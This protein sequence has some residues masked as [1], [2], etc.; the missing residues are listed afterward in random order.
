MPGALCGY[1]Q[2]I[3]AAVLGG[4]HCQH[5]FYCKLWGTCLLYPGSRSKARGTETIFESSQSESRVP[6]LTA[7]MSCLLIVLTHRFQPAFCISDWNQLR[8]G[9]QDC[10]NHSGRFHLPRGCSILLKVNTTSSRQVMQI[11]PLHFP[12]WNYPP[13]TVWFQ[14][15]IPESHFGAK[16][17]RRHKILEI[18]GEIPFPRRFTAIK[19]LLMNGSSVLQAMEVIAFA[20]SNHFLQ[21]PQL[22][23]SFRMIGI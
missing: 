20:G 6:T 1:S 23:I 18:T 21:L 9:R 7:E 15:P 4:R 12:F 10:R 19:S 16:E 22:S 13:V 2:I 3:F 14:I 5:H 11:F 17:G 8:A